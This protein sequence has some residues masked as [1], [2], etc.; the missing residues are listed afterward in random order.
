VIQQRAFVPRVPAS[1]RSEF[2]RPHQALQAE[3]LGGYRFDLQA[4]AFT[5]EFEHRVVALV[6]RTAHGVGHHHDDPVAVIDG[7]DDGGQ[8]AHVGLGSGYDQGV[9][10]AILQMPVE[11]MSGEG[12]GLQAPVLQLRCGLGILR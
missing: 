10:A 11:L 1:L 8:H 4:V 2:C 7:A 5:V 9:G 6:R 3:S 12:L